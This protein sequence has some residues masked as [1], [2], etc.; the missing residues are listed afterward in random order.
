V[1]RRLIRPTQVRATILF[2]LTTSC[3]GLELSPVPDADSSGGS[4]G[5][6][7][8]SG[9]GTTVSSASTAGSS[10]AVTTG[11]SGAG[12]SRG[13]TGVGGSK[14]TGSGGMS[15]TGGRAGA[16]GS[17]GRGGSGGG[18]TK[19]AGFKD[20]SDASSQAICAANIDAG[21]T[22]LDACICASCSQQAVTCFADPGCARLVNCAY[23]HGCFPGG[24][25]TEAT[26]CATTFCAGELTEAG[27]G[28]AKAITY[29]TCAGN[30][31]CSTRCAD[32]GTSDARVNDVSTSD[33][34]SV[35]EG[36]K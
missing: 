4:A 12:G 1:R 36:G 7:P 6:I 16:S 28:L 29:S 19:D 27:P 2:A 11:T 21:S 25:T 34:T 9:S 13:S 30:A 32:G 8:T 15:G 14:P 20:A 17:A 10:T 3:G 33:T 22:C 35:Q 26:T 18:G 31:M 23:A 5:G 24:N